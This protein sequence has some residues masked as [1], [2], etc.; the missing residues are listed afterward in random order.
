[1]LID[2]F[3]WL[4]VLSSVS[5]FEM[6]CKWYYGIIFKCVIGFFVFDWFFF[7]VIMY[8]VDLVNELLYV[9]FGLLVGIFW[10]I[11]EK[12]MG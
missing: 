8:C 9:I 12:R 2:D 7:R 4:V 6:Y 3:Q 5:G 10:N 11:V 1:M